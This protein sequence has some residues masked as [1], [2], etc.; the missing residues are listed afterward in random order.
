MRKLCT[1]GTRRR[2]RG[3]RTAAA[4]VISTLLLLLTVSAAVP[5]NGNAGGINGGTTVRESIGNAVDDAGDAAGGILNGVGRAADDV[6]GGIG[7]AVGG[8]NRSSDP[9]DHAGITDRSADDPS[10]TGNRAA[11]GND[12]VLSDTPDD[13]PVQDENPGVIEDGTAGGANPG[14]IEDDTVHAQNGS[15]AGTTAGTQNP[16]SGTAH[17]ARTGAW[18][19]LIVLLIAAAIVFALILMPKHSGEY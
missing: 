15:T 19:L 3:L 8:T 12:R 4:L 2:H 17:T 11:D 13:A 7:N 10:G 6:L 5:E 14:V 1:C 18:V 16:A 9:S